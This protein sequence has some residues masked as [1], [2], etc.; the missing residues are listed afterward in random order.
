MK[1]KSINTSRRTFIKQATLA[2]AGL[3]FLPCKLK[4]LNPTNHD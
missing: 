2:G 1:S 4:A 3:S